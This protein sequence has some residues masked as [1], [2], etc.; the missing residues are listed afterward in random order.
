MVRVPDELQQLVQQRQA[1]PGHL[2]LE[3]EF[4]HDR[5]P[6]D[7]GAFS[8]LM[9]KIEGGQQGAAVVELQGAKTSPA[10]G[11]ARPD[12]IA[13]I[14]LLRNLGGDRRGFAPSLAQMLHL[15]YCGLDGGPAG[16]SAQQHHLLNEI[17]GRLGN[18][19]HRR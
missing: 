9:E 13:V 19:C 18:A 11:L 17:D 12:I 7:H 1:L 4:P 3:L 8:R 2:T 10:E 16:A 14:A 15:R 5:L 6:G